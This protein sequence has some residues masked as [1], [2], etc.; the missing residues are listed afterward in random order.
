[1]ESSEKESR[2]P[3]RFRQEIRRQGIVFGGPASMF[4]TMPLGLQIAPEIFG[5]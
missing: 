1:M 4:P 2:V 5:G 3:V